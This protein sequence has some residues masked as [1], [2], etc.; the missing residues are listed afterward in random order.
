MS[1]HLVLLAPALV[2][3]WGVYFLAGTAWITRPQ[4]RDTQ[5]RWRP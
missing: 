3:A 5:V 2:A 1:A 4:Q